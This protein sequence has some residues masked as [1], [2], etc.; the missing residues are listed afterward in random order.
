MSPTILTTSSLATGGPGASYRGIM[1]VRKYN[2]FNM[3]MY[4]DTFWD[5][6]KYRKLPA[7]LI[8]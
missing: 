2:V 5:H 3:M 1:H 6:Y 7:W 8:K 4:R